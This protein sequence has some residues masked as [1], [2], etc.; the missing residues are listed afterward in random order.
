MKLSNEECCDQAKIQLKLGCYVN[1][2]RWYNLA[3]ARTLGHKKA[4]A[5]EAKAKWCAEMAGASY[6]CGSYAE[7]YEAVQTERHLDLGMLGALP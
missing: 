7:D 3:A 6:D 2:M 1:A 5:Y 4:D